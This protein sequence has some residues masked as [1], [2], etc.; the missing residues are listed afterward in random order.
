MNL[1][2]YVIGING[3][4]GA[5]KSTVI[6]G[7]VKYYDNTVYIECHDLYIPIAHICLSMEKQGF[8]VEEI[9]EYV[10]KFL[11]ANYK[12]YR[13]KIIFNFFAP[14]CDLNMKEIDLKNKTYEVITNKKIHKVIIKLL[15][16]TVNE[17]KKNY[18]VIIVGRHVEKSYKNLDYHFT[19]EA[20]YNLRMKR[21]MERDDISY[22]KAAD[23][24]EGDN[25]IKFRDTITIDTT[26]L[27]KSEVVKQIKNILS[28]KN[29]RKKKIKVLFI[30]AACTGKTTIC[31]ALAKKYKEP[32]IKEAM[33]E[34]MEENDLHPYQLTE[35]TVIEANKK[36]ITNINKKLKVANKFLF[37]DSGAI[38]SINYHKK[39][40]SFDII[41]KQ[42]EMSDII[43]LCDNEIPYFSDGIRSNDEKMAREGQNAIIS[44]LKENEVPYILLHGNL[45]ERVHTVEEILEKYFWR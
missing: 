38:V 5:G 20:D 25:N 44:Y 19:I 31:K 32:Y 45:K 34:Y 14:T 4:T 22:K 15:E 43:F 16:E 6:K 17:L 12:I 39:Q 23:H 8:T 10:S 11:K 21:I 3:Q 9:E 26:H 37:C 36:Q 1:E 30:G 13:K 42:L 28:T 27:N 24:N 41:K 2:K 33:R 29:S 18:T 35:D 40:E 7:L